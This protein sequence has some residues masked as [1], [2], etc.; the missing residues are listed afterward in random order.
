VQVQVVLR[1]RTWV[2][3]ALIVALPVA[4]AEARSIVIGRD[5]V[6]MAGNAARAGIFATAGLSVV[7]S[8]S[9]PA[10]GAG[11]GRQRMRVTLSVPLR[12]C[13]LGP[14]LKYISAEST[15]S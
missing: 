11:P 12:T 3:A 15:W 14:P 8:T 1:E 5:L 2:A 6:D 10:S 9:R 7:T 4:L 13:R